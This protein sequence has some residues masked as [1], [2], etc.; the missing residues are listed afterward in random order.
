MAALTLAQARGIIDTAFEDA[1]T[2]AISGFVVVVTDAG[3]VLKAAQRSDASGQFS[4]EIALAKI[5]T[6]LGF[7]RST[8][9]MTIF[10]DNVSINTTLAGV[11]GGRFMPMG[12]GVAVVDAQ[13]EIIGGAAFSGAAA[14]VDHEIIANAVRAAGLAVLD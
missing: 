10:R 11:L 14:D 1:A 13:G 5:Q 7:R 3:G 4:V 6:A 12:G 9:S 2:R 8:Q